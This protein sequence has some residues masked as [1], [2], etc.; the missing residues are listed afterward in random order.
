VLLR[1]EIFEC[2]LQRCHRLGARSRPCRLEPVDPLLQ[3]LF[4]LLRLELM[5]SQQLLPPF[6]HLLPEGEVLLLSGEIHR[7]LIQE[8]IFFL[9]VLLGQGN[10]AGPVIQFP[11]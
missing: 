8:G 3:L 5:I 7:P 6:K 4:L 10:A 2:L 1:L 11:L 9:E